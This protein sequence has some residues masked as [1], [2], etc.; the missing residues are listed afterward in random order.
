LPST[1]S[2]CWDGVYAFNEESFGPT[3][4]LGHT[5]ERE[6]VLV[7]DLREALVRLNPQLRP[8]SIDNAVTQLTHHDFSRSLLQHNQAFHKLV[9][10]SGGQ[11]PQRAGLLS[12]TR[13]LL[14]GVMAVIAPLDHW[15]EKEQTHAEVQTFILDQVYLSLPEPPYTPLDKADVAQLVYRHI[16]Q[17]TVSKHVLPGGT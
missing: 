2:R 3:G 1:W 7:R 8:P 5:N 12:H 11:L 15:T 10:N 17:Q 9:S 4:T 6:A 16:R 13:D 14:A